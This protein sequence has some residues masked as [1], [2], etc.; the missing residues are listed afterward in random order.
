MALLEAAACGVPAVGTAV[1]V[2]PE[3]G[4]VA[5]TEAAMA[6]QLNDLMADDAGRHA[7]GLA[8][9]K[10]VEAG[11]SLASA[12]ERFVNLYLG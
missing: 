2:L 4:Q 5:G 6:R 9:R 7:A 3:I 10:Q 11:Y 1:G 12:V 8:A